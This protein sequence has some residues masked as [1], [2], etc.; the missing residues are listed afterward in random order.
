MSAEASRA[1]STGPFV[2]IVASATWLSAIDGFLSTASSSSTRVG[3]AS[4]RS[5]SLPSF[6]SAYVRI[7]SLTSTFLPLT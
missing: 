4:C 7:E 3:S 1:R 2:Q 6:S 5:A